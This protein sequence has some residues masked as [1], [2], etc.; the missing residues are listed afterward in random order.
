M[1]SGIIQKEDDH[2]VTV[3]TPNDTLVVSQDDIEE[4]HRSSH[5]IMPEGL[6]ATLTTE[7]LRDLIAYLASPTQVSMPEK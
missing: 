3:Q 2:T 4:R 6:L 7:E 1:I 5:S